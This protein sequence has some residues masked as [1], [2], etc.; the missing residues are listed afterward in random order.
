VTKGV[1]AGSELASL[2]ESVSM[3]FS[4]R[5]GHHAQA[6]VAGGK[7]RQSIANGYRRTRLSGI[8]RRYK[9]RY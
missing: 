6:P 8:R 4:M 2:M 1:K 3:A 5:R 9:H 7:M